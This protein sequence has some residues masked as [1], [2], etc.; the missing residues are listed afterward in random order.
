MSNHFHRTIKDMALDITRVA[1]EGLGSSLFEQALAKFTRSLQ[2]RSDDQE[3]QLYV[4]TKMLLKL[5]DARTGSKSPT[6]IQL[7]GL[8]IIWLA[9]TRVQTWTMGE[10]YQ[11]TLL[12]KA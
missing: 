12:R 2:Q 4:V 3:L 10:I 9:K 8:C 5:T 7:A 1:I 6:E 11:W